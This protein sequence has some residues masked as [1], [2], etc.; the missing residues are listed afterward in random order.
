LTQQQHYK[1][2]ARRQRWKP[3]GAEIAIVVG[4][5]ALIAAVLALGLSL[6]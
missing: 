3:D 5:V 2:D 4:V 1:W 6:R